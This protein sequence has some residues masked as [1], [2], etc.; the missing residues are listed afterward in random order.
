MTWIAVAIAVF[1]I[2]YTVITLQFRKPNP[3]YQP[4]HDLK[5]RGET[6]NLLTAGFQRIVIRAEQP[7]E[8]G[9]V[10]AA[11][12]VLPLPG[13]L[14]AALKGLLFD[15]PKLPSAYR[16]IHAPAS[17]AALMPCPILFDCVQG[18]PHRQ[19]GGATIYVRGETVLILPEY[20]PLDGDL[21]TRRDPAPVQLT[22]PAGTLA[23]GR[24]DV[25]LIG[26][27]ASATWTLQVH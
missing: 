11:A 8:A 1:I 10:T 12:A 2:G 23:P 7:A 16:D 3:S 21:R 19:P 18:D 25:G 20:D 26:A 4:Y 5:S 13:G 6:H 9:G 15:P 22:I 24:Y 17:V 27:D 14:P